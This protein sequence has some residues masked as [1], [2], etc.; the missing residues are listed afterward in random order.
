VSHVRF[1]DDGDPEAA[2]VIGSPLG[3]RRGDFVVLPVQ[4]TAP[5]LSCAQGVLT[6]REDGLDRFFAGLAADGRGWSGTRRWTAVERGMTVE[7]THTGRRVRL[8]FTLGRDDKPDGWSVVFPV[9]VTPGDQLDRI[10]RDVATVLAG[11]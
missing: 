4:V 6:H 8:V 1:R 2:L 11:W 10:A 9:E 3:T 7:A 5:G